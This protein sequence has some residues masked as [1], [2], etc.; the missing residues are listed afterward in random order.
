MV[1]ICWK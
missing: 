1:Y